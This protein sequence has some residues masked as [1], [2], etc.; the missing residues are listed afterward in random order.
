M[1]HGGKR[2]H[3]VVH[4]IEQ[5]LLHGVDG[6]RGL[7][8]ARG[9]RAAVVVPNG[10]D[11]PEAPVGRVAVGDGAVSDR[12]SRA[13]E[14]WKLFRN[15]RSDPGAFYRR[16]AAD[17]VAGFERRVGSLAG[18]R[19]ADIGCGPGYYTE[20]FRAAGATVLPIEYDPAELRLAGVPPAGAVV[21]VAPFGVA[22]DRWMPVFMYASLS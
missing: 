18:K 7:D 11:L 12:L 3:A 4:K 14:L 20:A 1:G 6:A 16:L 2:L 19:M 8:V 17:A 22:P 15:E 5:P 21:V 9:G 13:V 10:Y